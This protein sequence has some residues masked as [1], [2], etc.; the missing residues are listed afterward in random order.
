MKNENGYGSVYKLK[1]K[2]RNPWTAV[3]TMG[4]KQTYD[5]DG[6]PKKTSQKRE[7]IGYYPTRK[8]AQLALL[9]WHDQQESGAQA[10][11]AGTDTHPPITTLG[12]IIQERYDV[13]FADCSPRRLKT[14]NSL[15][16]AI[17]PIDDIPITELD[18]KRIQAFAD[19]LT[20]TYASGTLSNMRVVLNM[21]ISEAIKLGYIQS[22]PVQYVKFKS[23]VTTKKKRAIP[24]DVIREIAKHDDLISHVCLIMIYSGMR[25]GELVGAKPENYNK[26]EHYLISGEKTK[27]G[28]DRII[29][30]H[31]YIQDMFEDYLRTKRYSI[32]Y[33]RAKLK[34]A[35]LQYGF[36]F[37]A[38]ECRHTFITLANQYRLDNYSLHKIVGHATNDITEMVYTHIRASELY[39]EI[40]KIPEP[41]DLK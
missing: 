34:T 24:P 36:E 6:T 38:H 17:K 4:W 21:V 9:R 3:V 12:K 1:N 11:Q 35:C 40:C 10:P 37:T 27:A 5:T 18:Y 22:N 25:I 32:A 2:K 28:I 23:T 20:G 7:H 29:P 30:I 13:I 19:S 15:I 33:Y 41:S 16:K 26:E 14:V 31:P 8:E 39:A